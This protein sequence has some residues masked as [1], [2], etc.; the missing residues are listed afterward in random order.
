MD[1]QAN[2]VPKITG[3]IQRA[4]INSEQFESLVKEYQ[5]AGTLPNELE[6]STVELLIG[7]DYYSDLILLERKKVIPGLYL[8]GSHL[9]WTPS[10]R[11]P[12]EEKKTSEVSTFLVTRNSCQQYQQSFVAPLEN[13]DDFMKPILEEFWKLETI[14]IKEPINDC[15]DDLAIQNFHDTVTKTNRR[16]EVTWLWKEEN[17]QLPDNYQLALGRLNSLLKRIQRNAELLQRCEGIIKDQL[18]K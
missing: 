16:H 11:L 18:K 15:G 7:D 1:I 4:S 9:R 6:V 12:S 5:L 10:G 2:V 14:R 13:V 17:P 3:I 8:L